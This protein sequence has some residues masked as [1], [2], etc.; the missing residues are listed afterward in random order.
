[1]NLC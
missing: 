1:M